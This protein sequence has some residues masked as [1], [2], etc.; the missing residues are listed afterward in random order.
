MHPIHILGVKL[1]TKPRRINN[2]KFHHIIRN[3]ERTLPGAGI[4]VVV[5][6]VIVGDQGPEPRFRLHCSH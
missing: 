6:V 3:L 2:L 5:V 1:K 4:G